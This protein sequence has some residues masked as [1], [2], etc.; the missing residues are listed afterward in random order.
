MLDLIARNLTEAI[1]H[2]VRI[3]RADFA[4]VARLERNFI[5]HIDGLDPPMVEKSYGRPADIGAHAWLWVA[6][7]LGK[8]CWRAP[9]PEAGVR[10]VQREVASGSFHRPAPAWSAP[11]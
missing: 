5:G 11:Y 1:E 3:P 4:E 2:G 8:R 9:P 7:R 10:G 6:G